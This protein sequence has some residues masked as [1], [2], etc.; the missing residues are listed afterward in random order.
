[1]AIIDVLRG[2]DDTSKEKLNNEITEAL[3]NHKFDAIILD[4]GGNLFSEEIE[5]YYYKKETIFDDNNIFQP[6]TGI[7]KRPEFIY[8]PKKES[9][10]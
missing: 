3:Q 4:A 6:I 10:Q 9:N 1:M 2:G 5:K 8:V 7:K